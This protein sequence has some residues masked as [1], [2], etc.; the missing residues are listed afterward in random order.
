MKLTS[1]IEKLLSSIRAETKDTIFLY[2]DD[3]AAI[4]HQFGGSDGFIRFIEKQTGT[5]VTDIENDAMFIDEYG[6]LNMKF[7]NGAEIELRFVL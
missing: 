2:D 5:I 3:C 1:G 6:R 4:R 7:L